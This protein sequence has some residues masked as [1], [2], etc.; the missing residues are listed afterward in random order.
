MRSSLEDTYLSIPGITSD[1]DSHGNEYFKVEWKDTDDQFNPKRWS[2]VRRVGSTLLVCLVALVATIASSI[3]SVVIT[4]AAAELGVASI[5]ESLA[6][7]LFLVGFGA[8]ALLASPLSEL[9]GRFPV[10]I[11]SLVILAGW[12]VGSALSPNIASQLIFRFL[13]GLSASPPLTV[14]GGSI[15]DMWSPLER[16]FAFPIYAVPGFG[17][18]VL[19]PVIGTWVGHQEGAT[20]RWVEWTV[21]ILVALSFFALLLLK[22][23]TFPPR[24]LH[25]KAA[26]FRS[27]TGDP[28]FKTSTEAADSSSVRAVL[29]RN[30]MR[31]F[32]LCLE[33]IVVCFTLYLSIA[34]IILFTFLDGYT[35]IFAKVYDI[36]ENLSNTIFVGIVV[37]IFIS[38]PL[39]PLSYFRTAEQLKRDGDDG[40]GA[41]LDR[42]SRLIFAMIGAPFLPIA[43]FWMGWTDFA[44]IS[45]WSP[46]AASA[47]I[48]FSII[49]IFMS[50]NLYI[51]DSYE[52]YA[53]SALTFNALIRYFA[54]GGFTVV[55]IPLYSN[56]GT[57]YTLTLL[58]VISSL[59]VPIPYALYRWG[60][61]IRAR[62]SWAF[63]AN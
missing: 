41:K 46:I 52:M 22:R 26:A 50:A 61:A 4:K 19:G 45:I 56:L 62:S 47:L 1:V 32:L 35:D 28:R 63:S 54:A 21:L 42:E 15:S 40:S 20:W 25:I 5:V 48:G 38:A 8:G 55:G 2:T 31:P 24:I 12:T 59:V 6:T 60:P 49:C 3:D 58:G 18:A 53:A 51:I 29:K 17:G 44:W 10:Y 30:F 33:P 14:A 43:L 36:D 13:M 23:E 34:Y 57:H 37:G 16:T 7:A 9:V 27:I 11:V 39:V